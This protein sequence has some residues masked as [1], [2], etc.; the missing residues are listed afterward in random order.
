MKFSDLKFKERACAKEHREC[1]QAL[2]D[3]GPYQL[4][5]VKHCGSY[6]GRKGLYE[7]G[8]FD[9][10]AGMVSLPGITEDGDSVKGFLTEDDVSCIMKKLAMIEG[11]YD[12]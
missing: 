12:E 11:P 8:V 9:K 4:S 5:V 7:I 3:F 1:I 6:G 2:A 10:L